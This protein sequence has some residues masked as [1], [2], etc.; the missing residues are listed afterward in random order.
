VLHTP[1]E[2]NAQYVNHKTASKAV[3]AITKGIVMTVSISSLFFPRCLD[4]FN[5][6]VYH[7]RIG[8]LRLRLV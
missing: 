1:Y 8:K 7:P 5:D 4:N 2:Y 6:L 3:D